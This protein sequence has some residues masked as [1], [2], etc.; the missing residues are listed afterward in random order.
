M[1]VL[2]RKII[3]DLKRLWSQVIAIAL[4]T[5]T[6]TAVFV[7]SLGAMHSLAQTQSAYYERYYFADVFASVRRAP[8]TLVD[9]LAAIPGVKQVSSRITHNVVLDIKGM[10]EPVNGLL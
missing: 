9:R 3:R 2:D 5:A 8:E 6:G 7:M 4:V 1:R 10:S